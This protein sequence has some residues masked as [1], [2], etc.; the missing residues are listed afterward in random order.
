VI[1]LEMLAMRKSE[2][3]STGVFASTSARP[4]LSRGSSPVLRDGQGAPGNGVFPEL[5]L[6][7]VVKALKRGGSWAAGNASRRSASKGRHR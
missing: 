7:R 6:H 5:K 4:Y 1:G 3:A 2:P